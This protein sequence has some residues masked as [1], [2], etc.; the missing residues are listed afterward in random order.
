MILYHDIICIIW[1]YGNE[2]LC[3]YERCYNS[4]DCDT[5]CM[6]GP[7]VRHITRME[8]SDMG[9]VLHTYVHSILATGAVERCL[10]HLTTLWKPY[11]QGTIDK[12]LLHLLQQEQPRPA[13]DIIWGG[14]GDEIVILYLQYTHIWSLTGLICPSRRKNT[15]S[16]VRNLL[17]KQV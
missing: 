6:A 10:C 13:A 8:F 16:H 14:G 3:H 15:F 5:W 2:R 11:V 9:P 4:H 1:Y 7:T 12:V 17:Y